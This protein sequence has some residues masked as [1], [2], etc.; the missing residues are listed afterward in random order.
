[1]ATNAALA[2]KKTVPLV[3][4]DLRRF[5]ESLPEAK[6]EPGGL[7]GLV[8]ELAPLLLQLRDEK[9]YRS[10]NMAA[11]LKERGVVIAP[12]TLR[13][14]LTEYEETNGIRKSKAGRKASGTR[15]PNPS[16]RPNQRAN[17]S[18]DDKA[19]QPTGVPA[20]DKPNGKPDVSQ[21]A[22]LDE[23]A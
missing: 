8:W 15:R 19:K 5:I 3:T 7:K 9:R 21:H 23:E 22:G 11:V 14:Y 13:L 10:T 2:A 4:D 16:P 1:M 18:A 20:S 6:R 17:A 12:A